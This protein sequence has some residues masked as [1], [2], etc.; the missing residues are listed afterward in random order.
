MSKKRFWG[1]C[2]AAFTLLGCNDPAP[3]SAAT[4]PPKEPQKTETYTSPLPS[5]APVVSVVTNSDVPPFA[6]LDTYGNL[7]GIDVDVIRAVGE[8]EGFKVEFHNQPFGEI[9]PTV[10]DGKYQM[11]MA[12]FSYTPERAV[13]YGY[14]KSYFYSP[15]V[16]LYRSDLNLTSVADLKD[17]RVATMANTKHSVLMKNLGVQSLHEESSVFGMVQGIL[18]NEYDAVLQDK[19]LFEYVLANHDE[20]RSKFKV[21]EYED[22]SEPSTQLVIYT[23]KDNQELVAKLNK[24]IETLKS[25]GAIDKISSKYLTVK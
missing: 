12:A 5:D 6:F 23:H 16:V 4:E 19:V 1:I 22:S 24:G 9:L 14:T 11:A 3:E 13:E 15:S 25:E 7:Q 2:L 20:H 10:K 8:K 17:L 21:L 18:Q